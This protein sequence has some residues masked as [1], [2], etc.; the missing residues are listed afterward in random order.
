M[1]IC[2]YRYEIIIG[3]AKETTT[4][5]PIE[6]SIGNPIISC[7]EKWRPELKDLHKCGSGFKG[8]HIEA[9][10]TYLHI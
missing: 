4:S 10:I 9:I 7:L 3:W 1:H 5:N 8:R 2:I 6:N